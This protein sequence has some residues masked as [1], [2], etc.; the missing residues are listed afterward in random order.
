MS[1]RQFWQ[2]KQTGE[3][4]AVEVDD[5]GHVLGGIGPLYTGN[6]YLKAEDSDYTEEDS[7]ALEMPDTDWLEENRENFVLFSNEDEIPPR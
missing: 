2:S 5:D 4:Y 3:I 1:K 6:G 7:H